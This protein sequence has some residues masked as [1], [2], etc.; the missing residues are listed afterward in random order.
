[1]SLLTN[2]S[3]LSSSTLQ[4]LHLAVV[5]LLVLFLSCPS[6]GYSQQVSAN[7]IHLRKLG[8]V[9]TEVGAISPIPLPVSGSC[10][11]GKS[12]V[13]DSLAY[14]YENMADLECIFAAGLTPAAVPLGFGY[15]YVFTAANTGLYSPLLQIPYQGDY[16]MKT[17]MQGQYHNVGLMSIAG[18]DVGTALWT[19]DSL[20]WITADGEYPEGNTQSILM[21]FTVDFNL[22]CAP[23]VDNESPLG[24]LGFC[25]FH[26]SIFPV[27]TFKDLGRFVG[28]DTDGAAITLNKALVHAE[29]LGAHTVLFY[30]VKTFDL[31]IVPAGFTV[32]DAITVPNSPSA[33]NGVINYTRAGAE[34]VISRVL[35]ILANPA[36]LAAGVAARQAE[37]QMRLLNL[38]IEQFIHNN[39]NNNM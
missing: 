24:M 30:A 10:T 32:G 8:V 5:P 21:D 31:A 23:E 38:P 13:V 33:V 16:I 2:H 39:S 28:F 20:G 14:L 9:P 34:G 1:M 12:Y 22:L 6:H 17:Y 7:N 25:P 19:I 18:F 36:Q 11:V 26:N 37:Q 27:S 15:G 35:N 29:G 3:S 4:L